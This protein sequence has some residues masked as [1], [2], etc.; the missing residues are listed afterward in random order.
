MGL[1]A[2]D[3]GNVFAVGGEDNDAEA[4]DLDGVAGMNAAP[5]LALNGLQ[6]GRKIVA[7]DIGVLLVGAVVDELADG[8]ALDELRHA[9]NVIGVVVGNERVIDARDAGVFHC[10][11]DA[12]GIA[13][14]VIGP[15]GIDEQRSAGWGDEECGLAAFD[16]NGVDEEMPLCFGLRVGRMRSRNE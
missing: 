15:A 8:N 7:R 3:C 1:E 6:V 16:I 11:L 4:G 12:N 10:C 9:T 14:V 13:A 5:R 2:G